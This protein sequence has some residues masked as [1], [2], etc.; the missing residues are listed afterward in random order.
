M[1]VYLNTPRPRQPGYPCRQSKLRA[2]LT[3]STESAGERVHLIAIYFLKIS[4]PISLRVG[5]FRC[6]AI[7]YDYLFLKKSIRCISLSDIWPRWQW[8]PRIPLGVRLGEKSQWAEHP[9]PSELGGV[10]LRFTTRSR[11]LRKRSFIFMLIWF[12]RIQES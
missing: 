12:Y 10:A 2:R 11:E 7:Y 4:K 3:S 8:G 1:Q 5:N 9:P 6:L